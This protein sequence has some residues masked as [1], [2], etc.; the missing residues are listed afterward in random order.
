MVTFGWP[1]PC[2]FAGS[3][4]KS[5]SV[6][7]ADAA[8]GATAAVAAS[9][10]TRQARLLTRGRVPRSGGGLR[11]PIAVQAR[12]R[13]ARV[14]QFLVRALLLDPAVVEHHDVPGAADRGQAMRDHD[15]GAPREQPPQPVLD[16]RLGAN[17]DVRRR[18]V[19]DQDARVGRRRARE[20]YE[21]PLPCRQVP[22]ALADFGVV[23]LRQ[24][25]D[26]V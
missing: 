11:C 12:V 4:L 15:R 23:A 2:V 17:V 22:A 5:V 20:C 9:A 1:P 25:L 8:E 13:A 18:L 7:S 19:E 26:E 10:R 21:L 24:P 14:E 3:T 6:A 16:L